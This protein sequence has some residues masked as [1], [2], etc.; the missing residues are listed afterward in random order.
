[1]TAA[2]H[3]LNQS[4]PRS[5]IRLA[6][7]GAATVLFSVAA[8]ASG[9]LGAMPQGLSTALVMVGMGV[10]LKLTWTYVGRSASSTRRAHI[11]TLLSNCG[12]A[13]AALTVIAAVPRLTKAG[14]VSLL[15]IDALAQLW[16][17]AIM[18]ALAG[19]VRTLGWRAFAGAFL[20]GFL[21]VTGVARFVG[22]PVIVAL[23]T[24]S[25]FAV[26]I[27]VPVTEEICKML[28]AI[29]V[30]VLALRRSTI[31]PSLLDVVLVATW[32]A[33]GFAIFENASYGRGSFSIGAIPVFSV[34]FPMMGRGAAYGWTLV[35]S[36]HVVHTALIALGVGFSF[37]YRDRLPRAWIVAAVAI[38]AS[39]IEH[40]SQ[41]SIIVG[42]NPWLGKPLLLISLNGRLCALLLPAAFGYVLAMEW[43]ALKSP[44]KPRQWLLLQA[45]EAGRRGALLAVLQALRSSA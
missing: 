12:L 22:R 24:S 40:C 3:A 13:M 10:A 44:G 34:M 21:G 32:A 4:P 30:L 26:G 35:Q 2:A 9:A 18:T 1:M 17:L 33:A 6:V 41:N 25:V 7:V 23:G 8:F 31:R 16:T 27:W 37:L 5:D 29:L 19:P 39:L 38:A 14:G 45:P 42:L 15:L 20:F 28:P 11:A 43:R 36:G